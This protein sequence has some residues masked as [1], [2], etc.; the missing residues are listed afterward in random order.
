MRSLSLLVLLATACDPITPTPASNPDPTS[1]PDNVLDDPVEDNQRANTGDFAHNFLSSATYDSLLI[2]V[3]YVDGH[4]PS[5]SALDTM[6]ER[7]ESI[8]DKP[9]GITVQ[10]DDV[11][12][13]QGAPAWTT[14]GTRSLETRYRDNYRNPDTGVAVLHMLYVDGHSASDTE[15]GRVLGFAYQGSSIVMFEESMEASSGGLLAG[16]IEPTVL[17]HE[18]GHQLGLTNIGTP[19]VA[20][21]EDHDHNGHCD[22][23]QCIMYW[24]A[25]TSNIVDFLL[26]TEPD[27]DDPCLNDLSANGGL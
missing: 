15:N 22:N 3:D 26:S 11:I 19:M 13:D 27:F 25:E 18:V 14:S 23:D 8:L 21:H 5:T 10:V 20:P 16:E 6:V 7:F 4:A 12:P 1:D 9:G 17:I 24:A 2:E